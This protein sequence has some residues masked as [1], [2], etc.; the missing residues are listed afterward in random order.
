M[1][2]LVVVVI[3]YQPDNDVIDHLLCLFKIG[4]YHFCAWCSQA[5]GT[6]R[7]IVNIDHLFHYDDIQRY[8]YYPLSNLINAAYRKG[9]MGKSATELRGIAF[10]FF[11]TAHSSIKRSSA[12]KVGSK[13]KTV[14]P[15]NELTTLGVSDGLSAF[16]VRYGQDGHD[17]LGSEL[18]VTI[19]LTNR[20]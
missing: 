18:S 1:F 4:V 20:R 17:G 19:V 3:I 11:A 5:D 9:K 16:Q 10:A 2:S 8:G 12:Y 14:L 7:I 6:Y 15:P 13:V